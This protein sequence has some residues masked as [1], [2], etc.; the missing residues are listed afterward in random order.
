MAINFYPDKACGIRT[1]GAND[2]LLGA[3][4]FAQ[5]IVSDTNR[6]E[7]CHHMRLA[8]AEH[9]VYLHNSQS[10]QVQ[11]W[12]SAWNDTIC[13]PLSVETVE[14]ATEMMIAGDTGHSG[15]APSPLEVASRIITNQPPPVATTHRPVW[16]IIIEHVERMN[17]DLEC[18]DCALVLADMR[19][20]DQIGRA[21]YGVPLTSH[22]GR[23][24]LVD[25][26]QEAMDLAAYLAAELDEHD[27]GPATFAFGEHDEEKPHL[28]RVHAEFEIALATLFTLRAIIEGKKK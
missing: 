3:Q 26:Y 4:F 22:N 28:R 2:N 19:E 10:V 25:A 18:D 6:E 14:R 17:A 7:C 21:R 5:L 8:D 20:R 11:K 12:N 27:I 1:A 23:D 13:T 24:H 15:F 16:E 9:I